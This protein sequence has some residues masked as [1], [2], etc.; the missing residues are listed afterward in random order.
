MRIGGQ[1]PLVRLDHAFRL[2]EAILR[3]VGDA[4]E[5]SR[6]QAHVRRAF[7]QARENVTQIVPSVAHRIQRLERIDVAGL[8]VGFAQGAQHARVLRLCCAHS[9]QGLQGRLPCPELLQQNQTPPFQQSATVGATFSACRL[10]QTSQ[11]FGQRGPALLTFVKSRKRRHRSAVAG[12]ELKH[13]VPQADRLAQVRQTLGGQSRHLGQVAAPRFMVEERQLTTK[14]VEQRSPRP[15][16][17]VDVA[18]RGSR[19]CVLRIDFED[20]L[21]RT[22]GVVMVAE[23]LQP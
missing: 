19:L 14:E 4:F 10:G 20:P 3:D 17:R 13:L 15:T 12:R 16:S 8:R 22:D 2:I 6:A 1:N 7:R 18:Q 5:R 11:D 23:L 9:P 21:E